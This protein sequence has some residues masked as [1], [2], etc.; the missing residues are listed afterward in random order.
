MGIWLRYDKPE[1][2]TLKPGWPWTLSAFHNRP[3][4][5]RLTRALSPNHRSKQISQ[6]HAPEKLYSKFSLNLKMLNMDLN[7]LVQ[8]LMSNY[9]SF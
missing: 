5:G 8:G 9:E 7:C 4:T 3:E 1:P 6:A 2:I